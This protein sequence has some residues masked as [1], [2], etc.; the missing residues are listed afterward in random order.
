MP[1][2]TASSEALIT[3][4][5]SATAQGASPADAGT[6]SAVA[7][8][9][10][11]AA[12]SDYLAQ[13]GVTLT[14]A[15]E[16]IGIL[17]DSFNVNG[18]EARDIAS[19]LLPAAADIH[20]IKEGPVGSADEGR[21]MAQE[22]YA[23][24]PDAQIYFYTA[25]DSETD[26]ANGIA[27]LAA[28]GCNVIV[29]DVSYEDEPFYQNTGTITQAVEAA[30]AGGVSYFTAAGNQSDNFY[31]AAFNPMSFAL[32]GIGTELTNNVAGGS[33]YEAVSLTADAFLDLTLQWTQPFG[34]SQYD[35]GAGLYSFNGTSYS[36]VRNF[37]T[38]AL[39]G[40]PVLEIQTSLNV[41]AG[42]YYL[43]FYESSA[44]QGAPPPGTFKVISFEDSGATIDGAGSGAGSGASIGHELAAGAN[45]VAAVNV[46]ET[47]AAGLAVPVVE[48]YSSAGPGVT[49]YDAGGTLLATP[50]VDGTPQFAATDGS[51][52]SVF[53]PFDGT[54]AAAPNAAAVALLMLQADARLAP[55][56]VTYL[57]E[58]SAISTGDS[59]TGGA[60]LIQADTAVAGAYT[61]ATTPI[62][63]GQDGTLWAQALDWS[64]S[65]LPGA[66]V[67]AE[68]ADGIGLFTGAYE[69][70]FDEASAAIGALTVDGG[71]FTPASPDLVVR[72]GD[73]LRTGSLTLG[74]GTIDISGNLNDTGDFFSGS[75]MGEVYLEPGG[76]MGIAG[77]AGDA[78]IDFSGTGGALQLSATGT[79]DLALGIGG[80]AA[81]DVID[82]T[83]LQ[84][85][86]VSTVA[87]T[88]GTVSVLGTANQVL[89]FLRIS[90]NFPGIAFAPDGAGGTILYAA[91]FAAGTRILTAGGGLVP[92]EALRVG[93]S[94]VTF[95]GGAEDIVWIG[96]R[97]IR[98]TRHAWPELVQPVLIEA[99][100]LGDGVPFRDLAV[101]PDHA[102]Y[103][104]GFFI[105]A[106]A[107]LNGFSIRQMNRKTVTYYHLELPEHAV[108]FAEGAGAESYLETGNRGAFENGGA[109]LTLHPDFAQGLREAK[110]CA[111]FAEHGPAVEA[112]RQ[113]ILDRAGIRMTGDP[114]ASIRYEGGAAMIESRAAVPG[115]IFADPRDKRRL[116]V[117]IAALRIGG[118]DV[119]ID[120]PALEQGWHDPEPDGRWTNGCAVIPARVMDGHVRLEASI[121]A[122]LC[123]PLSRPE[124]SRF[125]VSKG[126]A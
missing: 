6:V 15:G 112:V 100:A 8:L 97:T 106:K 71:E 23:I 70:V 124:F 26:F 87:V 37:T 58:R 121:A 24:A 43:A 93:D 113:G 83:G 69:V 47:P 2:T 11:N 34:G 104:N 110:G 48:S 51:S 32:P 101:S 126:I 123:Y 31:E 1:S 77:T 56:Q 68:I 41:A 20:V 59:S 94:V 111:P 60:G 55:A 105:P 96:R 13:T 21:A 17:S 120:H 66:G 25:V 44:A 52:T 117:K 109:A 7:A 88:G 79:A 12:V 64:D 9:A 107:L 54:S 80:F 42:T 33:P 4:N 75:A 35:I 29:D 74:R 92:V 63:T 114:A 19:G 16:K 90:G 82:L 28:A 119:P 61:A 84:T 67:A 72:T 78:A 85:S 18:G 99:G 103:L 118:R 122:S 46:D 22:V 45:T 49:Y 81:G 10:V 39:G 102:F 86:S 53:D 116:G 14:G 36:L 91:C 50:L 108:L 76:E 40:D 57:L 95:G 27:R 89:D 98:L 62:W 30:I 73:T 125:M 65:A 38:H 115:E 5:Q 3:G